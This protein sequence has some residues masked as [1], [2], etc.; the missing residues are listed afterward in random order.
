MELAPLQLVLFKEYFQGSERGYGV[1]IY[2]DSTDGLKKVGKSW[3][4]NELV[5]DN[6][7][8]DHLEGRQGLG[9]VLINTANKCKF[10]VIDIDVYG[11]S[12]QM[13]IDAIDRNELPM[14]P[15]RSKSGGLHIYIFFNDFVDTVEA[16]AL[17]KKLAMVLSV[18]Q[19]VKEASKTRS[20][21]LEIFPKQSR[22]GKMGSW[23]NL[24]YYNAVDEPTQVALTGT[25]E[26]SLDDAMTLIKDRATTIERLRAT[27]EGLPF[28]DAPPCLQTIYMLDAVKKNEG[29][30]NYLFSWGAYFKKKDEMSFETELYKINDALSEPIKDEELENTVL[31]SLRRKDYNY[32]CKQSPCVNFCNRAECKLREYGVGKVDGF[33]SGLEFGQLTQY[34]Q[35][36]PYY[37]WEVKQQGEENYKKLRFTNEADIIRQDSFLQLCFRELHVLPVKLQIPAWFKIVNQS[38]ESIDSIEVEAQYDTSPII[39]LKRYIYEFLEERAKARTRNDIMS[40]RV[41][42][43]DKLQEYWFRTT[44]LME[45]LVVNKNFKTVDPNIIS[46]TL[47]DI[48]CVRRQVKTEKRTS[49]RVMALSKQSFEENLTFVLMEVVNDENNETEK[50]IEDEDGSIADFAGFTTIGVEEDTVQEDTEDVVEE[51][52]D[53]EDGFKFDKAIEEDRY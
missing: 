46:A 16:I 41:Y 37:E 53:V 4:V 8:Q 13:F 33:F 5:T 25:K 17:T 52:V 1:H 42:F 32:M 36:K 47:R 11:T 27:V 44:D 10:T 28:S 20:H 21:A 40:K 34:K 50:E 12:L 14:I 43:N 26:L 3:S 9:V 51:T 6:L 31:S 48:G 45:F 15:F 18:N 22:K 39:L 24:P 23:I 35:D 29:R 7:Y 2:D 30:N 38:L 19:F 49:I